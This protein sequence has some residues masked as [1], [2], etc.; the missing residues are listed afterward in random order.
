MIIKIDEIN[1]PLSRYITALA[2]PDMES[3]SELPKRITYWP[4]SVKIC[5]TLI[6]KKNKNKKQHYVAIRVK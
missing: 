6:I 2:G 4:A 3:G 5:K 1:Y